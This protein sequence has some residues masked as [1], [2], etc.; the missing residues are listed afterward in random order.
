MKIDRKKIYNLFN[1]LN[2]N[3]IRYAI[4]KNIDNELPDNLELNKDIDLIVRKGDKLRTLR[5]LKNYGYK[6]II[7]PFGKENGYEFLYGADEF[8]FLYKDGLFLD[9]SYQLCCKSLMPNAWIPLDQYINNSVWKFRHY[10]INNNWW[11]LG[12]EDMLIYSVIRCIF[13]KKIFSPHY[14]KYIATNKEKFKEEDIQKKLSLV[15]FKYTDRLVEQIMGEEFEDI[16]RNY[17]Q[18]SSY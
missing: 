18:F 3:H 17:Y 14:C 9:I 11:I 4:I 13:D 8:D 16:I 15:F 1:E 5:I 12:E 2:G 10:D 6:Q 7:H